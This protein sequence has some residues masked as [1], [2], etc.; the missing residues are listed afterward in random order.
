M[1]IHYSTSMLNDEKIK[2]QYRLDRNHRTLTIKLLHRYYQDYNGKWDVEKLDWY[3]YGARMYD[4][5]LGRFFTQD[6]YAEKYLDWTPYQY[7]GNNPTLF[8]DVNGDSLAINGEQSAVDIFISLINNGLGGY[9][10]AS[11]NNGNLTLTAIGKEGE[12]S[13][14]Q[15]E[16]YG[17]LQ[18]VVGDESTT[19][20]GL[21]E[22]DGTIEI[23]SFETGQIDVCD[24][25]KLGNKDLSEPT[26]LSAQG[27]LIH[28]IIEQYSKQVDNNQ[29]IYS[30]HSI[31]L[32]YE[33]SVN[34]STRKETGT[35]QVNNKSGQ[36]IG[37]SL[38][39]LTT[40]NKN[41]VQ[42]DIIVVNGNVI[43]VKI[44]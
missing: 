12:M 22:E 14:Q 9:Y 28:E 1:E 17:A 35:F 34:G 6:A 40:V 44:K 29:D 42:V 37:H 4:P 43:G 3:D 5:S 2:N 36:T 13:D 41:P 33:N 25:Q 7:A 27:A 26:A 18:S 8:I 11:N 30:A 10:E 21:V 38:Q 23:G 32:N 15:K 39:S 24:A 31:A 16:F 20:I 19:T